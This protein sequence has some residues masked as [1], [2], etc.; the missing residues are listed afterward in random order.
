VTSDET[1][2]IPQEQTDEA[3]L[4]LPHDIDRELLE[5]FLTESRL[6]LR[7]AW[8]ALEG[9]SE[10]HGVDP[11]TLES[12][13]HSFHTM[14]AD[15]ACSVWCGSTASRTRPGNSSSVHMTGSSPGRVPSSIRSFEFWTW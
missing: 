15:A 3:I 10:S 12:V 2:D 13:R 1:P 11:E 5:R 6:H 7:E 9:S 8:F 14:Q 4:D